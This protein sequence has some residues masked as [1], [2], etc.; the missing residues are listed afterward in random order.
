ML[1]QTN[2]NKTLQLTIILVIIINLVGFGTYL[3]MDHTYNISGF[4]DYYVTKNTKLDCYST[5]VELVCYSHDDRHVD[6]DEISKTLNA[7]EYFCNKVHPS[8][9]L[10]GTPY[11]SCVKI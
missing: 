3:Y 4:P 2:A 1:K 8:G 7:D 11:T 6:P 10:P 5:S 9:L